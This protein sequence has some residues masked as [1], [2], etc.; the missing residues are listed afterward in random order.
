MIAKASFYYCDSSAL[1]K[2]KT[3]SNSFVGIPS[4][5]SMSSKLNDDV[6]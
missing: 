2:M 5:F 1:D 3:P 6:K 4:L